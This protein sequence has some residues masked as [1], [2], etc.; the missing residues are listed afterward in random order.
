MESF[1]YD[2]CDQYGILVIDEVNLETH[3]LGSKLSND[4][5]W[6]GAYLDRVTRMVMRDKNHPSVIIWSLGNEAGRGP[7]HAAMS[8]WVHDFDYTR[9][10]HY[11]PAHGIPHVEGYIDPPDPRNL[12]SND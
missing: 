7:N 1:L 4:P 10:V 12:K 5:M 6:T 3:G 9:P 2:L 8:G 11:E